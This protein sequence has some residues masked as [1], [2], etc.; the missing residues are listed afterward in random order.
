MILNKEM[1]IKE[2]EQ[3]IERKHLLKHP[4]YLAWSAGKLSRE[5]LKEYAMQYYHHVQAFPSYLSG[6]HFHTEDPETRKHLVQ[7]LADEELGTPNHPELWEQFAIALGA[8]KEEIQSHQPNKEIQHLI[9]NFRK[10]CLEG[11][12]AEGLAALYTYESQIPAVSISKIDGLKKFY[13]MTSPKDWKYFSVHIIA[14]KEHAAVERKLLENY[15][16]PTNMPKLKAA[17]ESVLDALG[18]FLS[19]LAIQY[20]VACV[21]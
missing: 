21:N 14:D 15:V 10:V 17:T 20:N 12:V 19:G 13:G 16:S 2:L 11:D 6:I 1:L 18:D 3:L 7:N 5:C 4:F 9:A 8:T